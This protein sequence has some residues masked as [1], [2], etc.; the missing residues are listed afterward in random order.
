MGFRTPR[1]RAG[2]TVA[3]VNNALNVSRM[4]VYMWERRMTKPRAALLP[5]I[6]ALYNCTVDELLSDGSET[7]E[8]GMAAR[9]G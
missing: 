5:K 7:T 4:A 8:T 6:A 3:D 1:I 9:H 2:L